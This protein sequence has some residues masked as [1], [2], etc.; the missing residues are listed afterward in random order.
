MT[1]SNQPDQPQPSPAFGAAS[2]AAD[3]V[4]AIDLQGRNVIV[5]GGGSGL[6]LETSR[7]LAR[8]GANVTIAARSLAPATAAAAAINAEVGADRATVAALDLADL[9]SVAT[10]VDMWADK[11]LDILINNAGIMACPLQRTTQG[12]ESQFATNHLGHFALTTGLLQALKAAGTSRVV[13]LSSAGH[14]MGGIDFDDLQ[15]DRRDY[16]KWTA[17][18]QAKSA[19]AL[20][21]LGLH[22]K[23]AADGVL[24]FSVHPGGIMTG[25]QKSLSQE[26]MQAMGWFK[27]D[28]TT[29]DIFKTAEQ[30]AATSV[31]AATTPDL[32]GFGGSYLEDC[33][34]ASPA[35]TGHRA[36][37]FAPHIADV[38]SAARLWDVSER[39]LSEA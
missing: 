4:G 25:L 37:G 32:V 36:S 11:Q 1:S 30:G 24:S 31:W 3:V 14:K 27:D 26:E 20:M 9:A 19:N 35:E 5:T 16:N 15:F 33:S 17:Y 8:A 23:F 38:D 2:T 21:A 7:A 28:G 39:L 29:L 18:G 34:V 6:G 10:F 22:K 12:W 13:T